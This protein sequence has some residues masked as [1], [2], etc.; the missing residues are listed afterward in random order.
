MGLIGAFRA[1]PPKARGAL[2]Y[3]NCSI[4]IEKRTI[5][6]EVVDRGA[7]ADSGSEGEGREGQEELAL[8]VADVVV[9][10]RLFDA[11]GPFRVLSRGG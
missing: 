8:S 6:M 10:I 4:R 5:D 3:K 1:G 7:M 9:R 2:C 11:I